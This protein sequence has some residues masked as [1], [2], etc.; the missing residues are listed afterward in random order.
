MTDW[1]AEIIRL[2]RKSKFLLYRELEAE[3]RKEWLVQGLLGSGEASAV[4]GVPG[5][6][7]AAN[8]LA[9]PCSR[10]RCSTSRWNARNS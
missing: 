7:M 10:A 5:L 1:T 9:E 6:W 8:G 3:S 4:Y 2:A